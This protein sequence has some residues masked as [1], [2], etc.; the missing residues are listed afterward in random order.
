MN[1]IQFESGQFVCV[2]LD[3]QFAR[4]ASLK[5]CFEDERQLYFV[6]SI[7][8]RNWSIE[9]AEEYISD[10]YRDLWRTMRERGRTW[11]NSGAIACALT[12]R[13]RA[14]PIAVKGPCIICEDDAIISRDFIEIWRDYDVREQW[15]KFDGVILLH[16]A[17]KVEIEARTEAIAKFGRYSLHEVT[18]K[19]PGST[20][21][22]FVNR[23]TAAALRKIQTPIDATPDTWAKFANQIEGFRIFVMHPPP[24][25]VAPFESTIP[26]KLGSSGIL[27]SLIFRVARS[28]KW[29]IYRLRGRLFDR[30]TRWT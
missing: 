20:A 9:E 10:E 25:A 14:L 8:G 28:F 30:V 11:L 29:K 22:Y 27:N 13:D 2:S 7:D 26:Y 12:H 18:G 15:G 5:S 24:C 19:A 16:Y 17:S 3:D 1:E 21:C 6:Q 4:R 23:K